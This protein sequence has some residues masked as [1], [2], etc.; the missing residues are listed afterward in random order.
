MSSAQQPEQR[1]SIPD[2]APARKEDG[3]KDKDKKEDKEKEKDKDKPKEKTLEE[4]EE[5]KVGVEFNFVSEECYVDDK[6]R[7]ICVVDVKIRNRT[8]RSVVMDVFKPFFLIDH[9]KGRP[10]L[11]L[12]DHETNHYVLG[13]ALELFYTDEVSVRN[14]VLGE[15]K[16]SYYREIPPQTMI[17]FNVLFNDPQRNNRLFTG[18]T[19]GS[20]LLGNRYYLEL[21]PA[22]FRR[23]DSML[24]EPIPTYFVP[25]GVATRIRHRKDEAAQKISFNDQTTSQPQ[26]H[27]RSRPQP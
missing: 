4:L 6:L 11:Y 16:R 13:Y 2:P 26:V 3:G 25:G 10:R 27:W 14:V 9:A 21:L 20:I 5:G 15:T 8:R 1:Q 18:Y 19:H 23:D 24:Y 17:E 12:R 7:P 22:D